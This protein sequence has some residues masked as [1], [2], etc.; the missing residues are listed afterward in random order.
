M[1]YGPRLVARL[2]MDDP[3]WFVAIFAKQAMAVP[4]AA[5]V[6]C[7]WT[8]SIA[9]AV[10]PG[11]ASQVG[12]AHRLTQQPNNVQLHGRDDQIGLDAQVAH[13]RQCQEQTTRSTTCDAARQPRL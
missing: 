2:G 10:N 6:V 5:Q 11:T 7:A 1:D 12:G 4:A 9:A 13:G 8:E 3:A